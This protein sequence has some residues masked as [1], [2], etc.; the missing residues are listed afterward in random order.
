MLRPRFRAADRAD[1]RAPPSPTRTST[2]EAADGTPFAAFEACRTSP[3]APASSC[4]RTCA[5]CTASTRSWR[6]ASPSG[7]IRAVAIDYFGRT[8]GVAKR[9]DD[10][11][12]MEHVAADDARAACRRTSRAAVAHLRARGSERVFTVGFCFGGR[13]AWLAAAGGH[14]PRRRGRLLRPAG[15]AQRRPPGPAQRAREI[16]APILALMGG[17]DEGI[18]REDVDAFDAALAA[19]GVEHEVVT[20]DGR[21]ALLLRSQ[22]GGARGGLRRRL[23]AR[24]GLHRAP[25]LPSPPQHRPPA[26]RSW[27]GMEGTSRRR[28]GTLIIVGAL[29][30][31]S[32]M[33]LVQGR[34]RPA[35]RRR[36]GR[37]HPP[38]A[39]G[40]PALRGGRVG[41]RSRAGSSRR[42]PRRGRRRSA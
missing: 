36:H 37:D 40:R 29:L 15:R 14:G 1:R 2:L 25:R 5:A 20:Y 31:G 22:A 7:G 38:A 11:P 16:E 18:P 17:D 28:A 4:C 30:V 42:S 21:A 23:A 41:E 9:D 35:R 8:A 33:A 10:F 32:A 19:A 3:A 13:H 6:C 34:R 26:G 39:R 27:L 12:Y 24:A